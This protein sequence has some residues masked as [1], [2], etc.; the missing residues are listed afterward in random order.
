MAGCARSPLPPA[1]EPTV[2]Y[3]AAVVRGDGD[4]VAAAPLRERA[5]FGGPAGAR[6]R[7]AGFGAAP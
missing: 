1:L 4:I 5:R 7:K 6:C 3:G 2:V